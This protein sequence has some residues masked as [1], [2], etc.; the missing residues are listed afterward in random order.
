MII[1]LLIMMVLALTARFRTQEARSRWYELRPM[2]RETCTKCRYLVGAFYC[3]HWILRQRAMGEEV[4]PSELEK[5]A[6]LITKTFPMCQG[7]YFA[8]RTQGRNG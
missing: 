1:L 4:T 7:E 6:L 5:N 3:S 8:M 2:A